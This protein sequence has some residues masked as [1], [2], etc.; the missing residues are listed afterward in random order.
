ME[1]KDFGVKDMVRIMGCQDVFEVE[2][3]YDDTLDDITVKTEKGYVF[4]VSYKILEIVEKVPVETK[5]NHTY[6]IECLKENDLFV[7]V[8]TDNEVRIYELIETTKEKIK[9]NRLYPTKESNC[10]FGEMT[11]VRLIKKAKHD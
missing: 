9:A 11:L 2:S 6:N 10:N 7:W 4:D 3:L 8:N 5:E 1:K